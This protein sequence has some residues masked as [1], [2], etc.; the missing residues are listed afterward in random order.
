MCTCVYA[1]VC[2][3]DGEKGALVWRVVVGGGCMWVCMCVVGGCMHR[4]GCMCIHVCK[5]CI[6]VCN[7][8]MH[9]FCACGSM[10][11]FACGQVFLSF[12]QSFFLWVL[13][14][15]CRLLIK[16]NGFVVYKELLEII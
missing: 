5:G 4:E 12:M 6:C 1:C 10:H 15:N 8:C 14:C 11:A 7:G 2:V 16:V 9:V 13:L 3:L